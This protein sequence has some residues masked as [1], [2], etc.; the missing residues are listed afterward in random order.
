MSFVQ[1]LC[2]NKYF[3]TLITLF[4][5]YLLCLGGY[6]NIWPLFGA[7]N[8]LLSALVLISLAIF[9]KQLEEKALRLD[10]QMVVMFCVTLTVFSRSCVFNCCKIIFGTI[11]FCCRWITVI[12]IA[13]CIN[14]ISSFGDYSLW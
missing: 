11:C 2:T 12:I 10:I 14:D 7:A 9:L 1:K 4:I 13:L 5:G 3:A 6:M 8:Q